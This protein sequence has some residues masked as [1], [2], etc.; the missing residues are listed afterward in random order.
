MKHSFLEVNEK[1]FYIHVYLN[2][3]DYLRAK[4]M[5]SAEHKKYLS[6]MYN[7]L[8]PEILARLPTMWAAFGIL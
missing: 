7:F 1:M 8:K 5:L 3:N 6:S 4:S 2:L